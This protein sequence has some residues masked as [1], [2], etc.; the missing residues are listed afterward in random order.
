MA[1]LVTLTS[2]KPAALIL[3]RS[4]EAPIALEPMP[5]SHAKTMFLIGVGEDGDAAGAHALTD[6]GRGNRAL[7]ALQGLHPV[8]GL[9][10]VVFVA[11]ALLA[12]RITEAIRKDTVVA[13]QH[14]EGHADVAVA[15]G[16][17]ETAMMLPGA[18]GDR[19]PAPVTTRVKMPVMPPPIAARIII[20]FIRTYGK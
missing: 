1:E 18:A 4:T 12:F 16:L 19:R 6:Q 10:E 20:G 2:G 14:R 3:L 13:K 8:G 7:L 5:A 9:V 17:G 15:C 11:G